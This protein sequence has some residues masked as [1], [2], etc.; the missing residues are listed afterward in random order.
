MEAKVI[1]TLQDLN[2]NVSIK[3]QITAES[4]LP[5]LQQMPI[6]KLVFNVEGIEYINSGGVRKWILWMEQAKSLF[7]QATFRF[8]G[9]PS[10]LIKQAA[11]IQNFLPP[12][13][14]IDSFTV[15]YFC[16]SCS[17]SCEKTFRKGQDFK[18]PV[19]RQAFIK[20]LTSATCPTC[21]GPLEID[22]I[23]E[24]YVLSIN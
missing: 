8:E 24:H 9:V 2:L 11:T 18:L 6:E 15:P 3:G 23:P 21:K 13:S 16:E 4:D 14:S 10:V 12:G 20:I 5:T 19:D 17:T 22:A 1:S 7:P